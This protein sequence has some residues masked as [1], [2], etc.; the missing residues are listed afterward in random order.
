IESSGF[1]DYPITIGAGT[2]FPLDGILSIPDDATGPVP[3]AI[4]V[5]GSGPSDMDGTMPG[6]GNTIYL[7]IAEFLAANGVAVIRYDK[8]TFTHGLQM[9]EELGS[10]LTVWEES[11][12]D[13]LFA[14]EL[15]RADP[16]IDADRIYIIG[17]SLGGI[18]A[19]RIYAADGDFAGLVL[20]GA[21][22]RPLL[23]VIVEQMRASI[24]SA[25]EMGLVEEADMTDMRADMDVLEDLLDTL[26]D[27]PQEEARELQLPMTGAFAYYF[28]DLMIHSFAR[29]AADITVPVLV[30]QGGRDFQVPTDPDFALLQELFAGRDDVTFLLFA[31]L[32]HSFIPSTA[33]NFVEHASS[34]M[35]AGHVY[36]PALQDMIDWILS[37]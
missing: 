34:V 17:H 31:D 28:Q 18:L 9:M 22:P 3:A 24:A 7:E 27:M 29:Y 4:I 13:A 19:P 12:E 6:A 20:M 8:R 1:T 2:A 35:E 26:P 11:I 10:S 36:T 30:M 33:T 21:S 16:R 25:I 15:L 14:A 5:H 37:R 23:E 32:N